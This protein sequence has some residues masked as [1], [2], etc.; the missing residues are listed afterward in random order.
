MAKSKTPFYESFAEK[1]I[2]KLEEGTAP[3]QRPWKAGEYQPPFNPVSGVVYSGVNQVMLSADG[4]NDPRYMTYKQAASKGWQVKKGARSEKI[5]FWSSG[6]P[7][8][9]KDKE[10]KP[11]LDEEGKLQ[12]ENVPFPKPVLRYAS[13]FHASQIDGIPEWDGREISWNPD[14]RAEAILENSGANITHDQRDRAFYSSSSDDIYLP[15]HAAFDSSDKYYSTALHEL[16]HWTGHESRLDREFGPR[17]SELYAR[18]ELRAEIASWMVS[19]EIGLSHNPEQHLSYVKSWIKALKEEPYEIVRACRDADKIKKYTLAFEKQRSMEESKEQGMNMSA[20]D[21]AKLEQR[22]SMYGVPENGKTYLKVPFSEKEEAKKHGA[23]WDKDQKMWFAPEGADLD[24]LSPW[25][26][27][28]KMAAPQKEK[29]KQEQ[30]KESAKNIATEKTYLNV[31]YKEKGQAKK[32]GARWDKSAKLWFAAT[33]TDLGPLSKWMPK[34]KAIVPAMNA[35]QEFAKAIQGAGLDLRGE[36]PIMDGNLHRVPVIDGKPNSKDGTYKGFLDGHPAGFIQN[37]KTGLKMNWKA[38]GYELTEEQKAELKARAAQKKQERDRALA[39]QREKA[40]KRSYAKWQN[41]KGWA[42]KQ[43]EYLAKKGVHSYGVRV[44]DRGDLLIPGKDVNGH[45]HTLQTI[46]PD[47]KLFEKG[48]LKTGM[49]HTIDPSERIGRGG[50]ILIA[51]GYATAASIHMASGLPTIVAFDAA[52]LE[53]VAKALKEKYPA[54]NIVILG[55]NDH[56]LKNNVGVEKAE[57]AAK[58]VGG[59]MLTPKFTE[60]EKA[61]GFSDFNDLHQSRGLGELKKQLSRTIKLAR[62]MKSGELPLA[63]AM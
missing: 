42:S 34:G 2:K 60:D 13:V 7:E 36:L 45:I 35:E 57:A 27:D 26:P 44:N 37:H 38:E 30:N 32:L 40:S 53:P 19:S 56:H 46:T 31:P 28:G 21:K 9:I 63:M 16:G 33:G 23:K 39:E 3:W 58:A 22:E 61:Q 17:G 41:A 24:K 4:L 10:G 52:N 29:T 20:P 5:V 11:V 50:P 8:L 49:F 54:S 51:E 14:D 18:E 43:Q 12:F 15:P 25:L 6:R 1:I 47:G 59:L 48:G 62:N 55:D